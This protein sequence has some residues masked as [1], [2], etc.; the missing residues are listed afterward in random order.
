MRDA[1][2][3]QTKWLERLRFAAFGF[4]TLALGDVAEYQHDA[5]DLVLVVANRRR[6]LLDDV[7]AVGLDRRVAFS[8]RLSRIECAS[9]R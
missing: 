3:E 9:L 2:G 5:G 1:T 6:D 7:L 8:G 4:I